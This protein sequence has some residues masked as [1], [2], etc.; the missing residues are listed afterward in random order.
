M[1]VVERFQVFAS[2][3]AS[4]AFVGTCISIILKN[5]PGIVRGVGAIKIMFPQLKKMDSESGIVLFMVLMTAVI[6]M[7]F[8][9][10]ILTQSMNETNYAQ[11][12]VDQIASEQLAKGVFWNAYSNGYLAGGGGNAVVG[13]VSPLNRA[14]GMSI[15]N[16][17][18]GSYSVSVNYDT[19]Q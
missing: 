16:P 15:N 9:L 12:Q 2:F 14:Y 4:A 18:A 8:C 6:I 5:H 7:I 17:A 13:T 3:F 1:G 19:F 11:Q 10:G